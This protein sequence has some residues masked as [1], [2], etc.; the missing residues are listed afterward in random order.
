MTESLLTQ[1]PHSPWKEGLGW[2]ILLGP[3]F[4]LSYGQVNTFTST[5]DDVGSLVFGWEHSIPF[6]PWTIVPYWSIDL[7]YGISL[8]ICTSK[9][10]LMRHGCRLLAASLVACAA[11]LLFPLKFTFMRPETQG[12]FGWLFR[13]LEQF[14]LPYNQ[15]PSLHI[16]LTWLLWLRFRQHLNRHARIVSGCWFLLIA[17]SVLTTWQHHFIDV[18]SGMVV[19]I[20]ISY[21]IPIEGEWR[22]QR[23]T[24]HARRLAGKYCLG[25][26]LFLLAGTAIPCGYWLLWPALAL[27]TVAAGYAGLGVTVFQKNSHGNLSLSARMLLLPY[28]AGAKISRRWFSRH[29]AQSNEI[30]AGVS[31][32]RFPDE[33]EQGI[34]VFDLTAEFHKGKR[35]EQCWQSYPLMD[36]LVP[37]IQHLRTAVRQLQQLRQ[38]HDRV[39]VCCALG[40]SR[41]AT[42]VAAWLLAEG[43]AA[44]AVQAVALVTSRRPQIVLTPAHIATLEAFSKEQPCQTA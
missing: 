29:T 44:S 43:Y 40:L 38:A 26:I 5:R 21:V 8:F 3:L 19:A 39:L 2:L 4:F 18:I 31:L 11:F 22:W 27:L 15:A 9:Q 28:L 34:A 35:G 36:L 13:Q 23:P 1:R 24:L 6:I 16:I 32:G 30:A 25:G 41:S 20:I 42:V 17:V 10:E 7:L 33:A 37:D 14:D 12:A